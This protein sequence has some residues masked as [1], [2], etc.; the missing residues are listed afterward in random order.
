M[1][2][3][4]PCALPLP[5]YLYL[6]VL[7]L[8]LDDLCVLTNPGEPSIEDLWETGSLGHNFL[9][10]P[11]PSSSSPF[12]LFSLFPVTTIPTFFPFRPST[13]HSFSRDSPIR[14]GIPSIRPTS[15]SS[16]TTNLLH[17]SHLPSFCLVAKAH[18]IIK[19]KTHIQNSLRICP[20]M[21]RHAR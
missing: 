19:H 20:S 1:I 15:K 3:D 7:G 6:A 2:P 5:G 21:Y 14:I 18:A 17:I 12:H 4:L 8:H 10:S 11:L 9:T 16:T 13:I